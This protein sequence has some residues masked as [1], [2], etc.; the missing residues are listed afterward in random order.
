MRKESGSF[1]IRYQFIRNEL[2]LNQ[3]M[4]DLKDCY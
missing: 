2:Q 1:M 4:N 3:I